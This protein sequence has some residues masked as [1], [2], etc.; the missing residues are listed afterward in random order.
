MSRDL[1]DRVSLER[2]LSF[3][4]SDGRNQHQRVDLGSMS[5]GSALNPPNE[6]VLFQNAAPAPPFPLPHATHGLPAYATGVGGGGRCVQ[7][8]AQRFM[9]RPAVPPSPFTPAGGI[10]SWA[11]SGVSEGIAMFGHGL[12]SAPASGAG[13]LSFSADGRQYAGEFR[14]EGKTQLP[15]L[16]T[17]GQAGSSSPSAQRVQ[18]QLVG[19]TPGYGYCPHA[20][21]GVEAVLRMCL[22]EALPESVEDRCMMEQ[23]V[24]SKCLAGSDEERPSQVPHGESTAKITTIAALRQSLREWM[25]VL[26]LAMRRYSI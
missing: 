14:K 6:S 24:S 17:S 23:R 4:A 26:K 10:G 13:N 5:C 15:K 18:E 1:Q 20:D 22:Q 16:E 3:G 8:W 19:E 9:A 2:S 12:A 7:P 21:N 25:E 11:V